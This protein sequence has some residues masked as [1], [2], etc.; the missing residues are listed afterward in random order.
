MRFQEPTAL[1][2]PSR[3][4]AQGL[5]LDPLGV[6][7]RSEGRCAY[8]ATRIA[9]GD[10]AGPFRPGSSFCDGW[11][12]GAPGS[13]VACGHCLAIG[14]RRVLSHL[15]AF[16]AS[17]A[18]VFPVLRNEHRAWLLTE[19]PEPPFVA[20]I[21]T[22]KSQHLAWRTPVSLCRERFLVRVG[23]RVLPV[24]RARLEEARERIERERPE[25]ARGPW[26]FLALDRALTGAHHGALREDTPGALARWITA[27][28]GAGEIWALGLCL[29]RP[30][31]VPERPEPLSIRALS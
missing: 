21:G 1:P 15:G 2:S 13:P 7:A 30:V 11:E 27:R 4:V 26:P 19:G 10:I 9:P 31:V 3:L 25:A 22:S 5:G 20:A 18:G 28:L 6:P 12:V 29:R 17:A 14:E 24:R 16:V 23:T 8:C